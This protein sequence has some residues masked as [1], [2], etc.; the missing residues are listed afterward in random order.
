[1]ENAM[2]DQAKAYAAAR[3]TLRD[4]ELSLMRQREAVAEL[5]RGLPT[6]P[7]AADYTFVEGPPE[8]SAGDAPVRAVPLSDLFTRPE[9]PLL[10]YHFMLGKAQTQPCPMCTLWTTGFNAIAEHLAE[11]ANLAIACAATI[12]ELRGLARRH[13]WSRL[14]LL[15]CD[16]NAFK[17]D[18]GSEDEDGR[19]RPAISV[20]TR[21]PDGGVVHRYTSG[22]ALADDVRERGLDLLNPLWHL[23]DLTPK[24]RGAWYPSIV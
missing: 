6:D 9:Q 20:F 2:N 4:A 17:A 8:L 24:G 5:R 1:M 12:G 18:F 22:I 11:H 14:R 13:E 19:Q 3:Q 21:N 15:S 16:D 7:R 23:L 10:L